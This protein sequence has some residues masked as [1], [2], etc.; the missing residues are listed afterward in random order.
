MA[1]HPQHRDQ[2]IDD[3]ARRTAQAHLA[4]PAILFLEMCK[5]LA[6][7]G[8]QVLWMTQPFL[9]LRWK[10]ADVR[11]LACLFEDP[12]NVDQLIERIERS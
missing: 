6:F 7:L 8:A 5:P 3:L 9:C 2:L 12:A 11:A 4:A 10:A 1:L